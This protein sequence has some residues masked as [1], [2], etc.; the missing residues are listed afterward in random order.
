MS[1]F[2]NALKQIETKFPDFV[3]DE[4]MKGLP[5]VISHF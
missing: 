2:E 1:E 4:D 3:I 5:T